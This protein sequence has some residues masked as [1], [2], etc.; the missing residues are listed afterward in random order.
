MHLKYL[1]ANYSFWI[2]KIK[3]K[4]VLNFPLRIIKIP[5][6]HKRNFNSIQRTG[7]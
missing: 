3:T 1:N 7:N 6:K 4:L 5:S 2:N